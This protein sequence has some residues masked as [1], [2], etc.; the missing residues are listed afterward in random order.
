MPCF[1]Q[2]SV[3]AE[4]G[5]GKS[6]DVFYSELLGISRVDWLRHEISLEFW[7]MNSTDEPFEIKSHGYYG[8]QVK[9]K[10]TAL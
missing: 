6:K 9:R 3:M 7:R 2:V 8:I 5:L 1:S 10:H 4:D